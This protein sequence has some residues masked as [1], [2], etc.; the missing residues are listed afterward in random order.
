MMWSYLVRNWGYDSGHTC[1]S[2]LLG[3][4][5]FGFGVEWWKAALLAGLAYPLLKECYDMIKFKHGPQWDNV[6]DLVSYQTVWP[7]VCFANGEPW[8]ALALFAAIAG[9]YLT[10]V[11]LKEYRG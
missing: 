3:L 9:S 1:L 10:L 6:S 11:D 7:A 2:V 4:M 8:L 5:L